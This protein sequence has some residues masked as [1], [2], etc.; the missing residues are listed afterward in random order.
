[1]TAVALLLFTSVSV[2]FFMISETISE[3]TLLILFK[4]ETITITTKEG[5][6][7][8]NDDTTK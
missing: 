3:A 6:F 7:T 1:M 5:I 2:T 8:Q 4:E